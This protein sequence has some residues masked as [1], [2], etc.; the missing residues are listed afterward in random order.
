[1]ISHRLCLV[2]FLALSLP[3]L[4]QGW[5]N[6]GGNPARNGL[7][8]VIGP[9]APTLKWSGI[10]RSS[11]IAWHPYIDGDRVFLVRQ[12]GFV[13]AGEPNGSPLVCLD[14]Q[15]GAELWALSVPYASG[16][17][18]T[19]CLGTSN[20]QV[21]ASRSGNG[22]TSQTVVR[23]Y[24]QTTGAQLWTS[25]DLVDFGPYD[26][27]VFAPNG[28]LVVG[29][30][31]NVRRISSVDG[32]TVWETSRS[33]NVSSSCGVAI[34]AGGVYLVEP[35]PGG[36]TIA[37]LDLA[38]GTRLYGSTLMP[39]FTVQNTPFVGP[40]GTVYLSRTQNNPLVD[41]VF[42]FDDDGTAL[43]ERWNRPAGWSTTGEWGAAPDGDVYLLAPDRRVERV[44]PMTGAT[45]ASTV[46]PIDQGATSV[47]PHFAVDARGK[48]FVSNGG[49]STGTLYA[50]DPDLT[51]R[52][53]VP[54]TNINQG[55]PAIAADGTLVV[56]GIGTDVRAFE[57]PCP[58]VA[59]ADV[60]TAGPNLVTLSG[61]EP[62]QGSTWM[63]TIDVAS[64][65][66]ALGVL[67]VTRGA[68]DVPLASGDRLLVNPAGP[69]FFLDVQPGPTAT[70]TAPIPADT[71]L[72][73]SVFESQG[74]HLGGPALRLTNALDLTLGG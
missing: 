2:A 53:S 61:D 36:N 49:F 55:G 46:N 48:V 6:K 33:C 19:V 12:T 11:I 16:D 41:F 38:S 58:I 24:D 68:I 67:L 64:S 57:S 43:I 56:A 28:D 27:V 31:T 21:Y 22:A 32:S 3:V 50:F 18:T 17:W 25:A 34:F 9:P 37:K 45:V 65:G 59:R 20:G 47:S 8:P 35:A 63:A 14:L 60:R 71:S 4:A 1:M 26:G 42:A 40:D 54:V 15:T 23:A 51:F 62:V 70:F 74:A 13:P 30:F 10:A 69:Q 73:G 39:G 66:H 29:N 7:S 72:C 52:W 44:D 5:P